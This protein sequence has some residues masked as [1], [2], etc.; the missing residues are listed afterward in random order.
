MKLHRMI[1]RTLDKLRDHSP[2]MR[3]QLEIIAQAWQWPN[4]ESTYYD[5][6][7]VS[8]LAREAR[9]GRCLNHL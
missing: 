9:K 6:L 8:A 2:E 4:D 3:K 5:R 7:H 1:E